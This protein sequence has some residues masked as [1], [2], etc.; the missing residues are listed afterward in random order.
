[1][2]KKI[3]LIINQKDGAGETATEFNFTALRKKNG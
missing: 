1:M 3:I 2:D